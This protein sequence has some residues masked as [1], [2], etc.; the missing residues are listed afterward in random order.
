MKNKYFFVLIERKM[1][2]IPSSG[3]KCP[4]SS[5]YIIIGFVDSMLSG[6]VSFSGAI[7]IFFGQ[8]LLCPF[9][10]NWPERMQAFWRSVSTIK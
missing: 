9:K 1:D 2:S 10:N 3:M 8:R 4:K 7:E 6:Q 5:L